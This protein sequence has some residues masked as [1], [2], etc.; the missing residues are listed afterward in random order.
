LTGAGGNDTYIVDSVADVIVEGVNAGTDVAQASVTYTLSAHVENLILTG[1][2]AIN[3]TGNDLNNT[4]TGND[5]DNVLSGA[6]GNDTLNGGAGNDTLDG[7]VGDDSMTGGAGNDTYVVDSAGDVITE[8]AAAGTDTVLSSL[9]YTL[10][11]ELENLT[12]TGAGAI[13][14]TGNDLDNI[15]TGNS[16]NNTLTGNGGND[17]LNGGLGADTMIGGFGNDTYVVNE[18]GDVVTETSILGGTDTVQSSITYTLGA[19]LENLTLTGTAAIDGYGNTLNNTII[20]NDANNFLYGDDGNDTLYGRSGDD[21]LRGNAGQ[22][23]LYGEAGNDLLRGGYQNDT[24]LGGDGDDTLVGGNF[25][26]ANPGQGEIDTLTGG[27]GNDTFVLGTGAAGPGTANAV[28]YDDG[29]ATFGPGGQSDYALITDFT[30]GQDRIQLRAPGII[31]DG[32][33][34]V[35]ETINGVSG[36]AIYKTG[37]LTSELIGLVKGVDAS[38]LTIGPS[39]G[40]VAYLS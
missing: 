31:F 14:G 3:G 11:A 38:A 10:G 15:I 30:D 20:G 23:T 33:N 7:G 6:V 21:E 1:S 12:L 9:T 13:S 22:D 32:Y 40:G 16:A 36:A 34:I 29:V 25:L 27:A 19:H 8:A 2:A 5:S 28:Y 18:L 4:I 35:N 37:F 24:L 26:D 39:S 17:T